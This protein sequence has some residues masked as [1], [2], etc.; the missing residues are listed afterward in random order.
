MKC[1]KRKITL[2]GSKNISFSLPFAGNLS[3]EIFCLK[4]TASHVSLLYERRPGCLSEFYFTA[5]LFVKK[6][7]ILFVKETE[8]IINFIVRAN[9]KK[10]KLRNQKL[11][12]GG[13]RKAS[14]SQ[15]FL[16]LATDKLPTKFFSNNLC[17]PQDASIFLCSRAR[18]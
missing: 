8:N 4:I 12:E 2:L 5:L 16:W 1:L 9:M 10:T 14:S 18:L 13:G 7:V 11:E 6:Q 3:N 17:P 15:H